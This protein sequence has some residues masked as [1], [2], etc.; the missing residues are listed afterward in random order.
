MR[1]DRCLVTDVTDTTSTTLYT[2]Q[3]NLTTIEISHSDL[4]RYTRFTNSYKY[5]ALIN[6]KTDL[7]AWHLKKAT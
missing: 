4:I 5:P 2:L 7:E 3:S 6:A 1:G